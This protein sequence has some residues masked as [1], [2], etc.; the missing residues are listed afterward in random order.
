MKKT[1]N[2]TGNITRTGIPVMHGRKWME[3]DVALFNSLIPS[4]SRGTEKN[5]VEYLSRSNWN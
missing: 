2:C 5:N 1:V 3:G 4:L